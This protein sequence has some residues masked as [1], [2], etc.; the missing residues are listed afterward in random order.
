MSRGQEMQEVQ[1]NRRIRNF[2]WSLKPM[3][4]LLG[5][6]G[7]RLDFTSPATNTAI[8]LIFSIT[9]CFVLL[10]VNFADFAL[11]AFLCLIIVPPSIANMV[12]AL[13]MLSNEMGDEVARMT[14]MSSVTAFVQRAMV[15]FVPVIFIK[16]RTGK[17]KS[18]WLTLLKIQVE[19]ELS[20]TFYQNCR[21]RCY[22][23]LGLLFLVCSPEFSSQ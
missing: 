20:E 2:S 16:R 9:L 23:A 13:K 3:L 17:W 21:R 15:F 19:L 10:I 7:I 14:I 18:L 8:K 4:Y 1:L 6:F 22:V 11:L 12:Q 5:I